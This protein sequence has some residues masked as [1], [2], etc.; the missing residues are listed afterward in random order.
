MKRYLIMPA[1]LLA[2][3][4]CNKVK[5]TPPSDFDVKASKINMTT[6][7]TV[8]FSFSGNPD[9]ITFYSGEPNHRYENRERLSAAPDSVILN[10]STSTTA[11]SATT[12]PASLNNLAV[13]VSKDFNGG[14][15]IASLQKATWTDISSRAKLATT[16]T[17]V[18]SGNVHLEDQ[19]NGSSP[20]YV[21]F[22]YLADMSTVNAVSRKWTVGP[23]PALTIRSFFKDTV[24][25]MASNVNS[26]GL[27]NI[28]SVA[29][30][31]NSWNFANNSLTFNAPAIGSAKDEDWA[32]SRPL[33]LNTIPSDYG[34]ILKNATVKPTDFRYIFKKP[35]TYKVTF[36]AKNQD[37]ENSAEVIKE[38]TFTIT[39]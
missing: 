12:Q 22:R 3:S 33:V 39:N 18:A 9:Y 6:K 36:V 28:I 15:D 29:N 10:F 8:Y 27:N 20:I 1:L 14:S 30:I 17:A 4:A 19:L 5:V 31:D 24:N 11:P 16:T 38:F 37:S 26:A 23:T 13:L 7:D 21:A 25:T 32:I 35:G 2:L 34:Q